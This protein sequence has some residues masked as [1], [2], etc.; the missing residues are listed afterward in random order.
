VFCISDNGAFMLPN[1]GLEVQTNRPLRDGGVTTYEG[2]VRVPAIVRWPG[3]LKANSL[4]REMLS[5]LDV[6]PMVLAAA[7][8][9]IPTDR[10]LD[11]RDPTATLAGSKSTPHQALHWVWEQGR[12]EQ[13]RSMRQGNHKIVR[14]AEK[15]PWQLFDLSQDI[16]ESND[17][18]ATNP[19]LLQSL[20]A[21]FDSWQTSVE[22]DPTRGLS[23]R[24]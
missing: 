14:K 23:L 16:S 17:L 1:R 20:V 24:K 9:S 7:G 13:W 8:V 21:R 10:T 22:S 11:G 3:R 5:S 2:G 19:D 12:D 6:L 4:C 15:E 18:A